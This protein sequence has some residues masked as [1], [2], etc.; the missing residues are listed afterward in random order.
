MN[1]RKLAPIYLSAS[2]IIL[3]I[4]CSINIPTLLENRMIIV[5]P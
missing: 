2:G 4:Y 1:I 5:Y 3:G